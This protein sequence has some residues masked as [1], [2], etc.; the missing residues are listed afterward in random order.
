MAAKDAAATVLFHFSVRL[1]TAFVAHEKNQC[2]HYG[3]FIL[4]SNV[5]SGRY[6]LA[7]P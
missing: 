7:A 4:T 6:Q 3:A 5:V 1:W 2:G